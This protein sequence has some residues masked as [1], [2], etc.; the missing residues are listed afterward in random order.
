MEPG[1]GV[2]TFSLQPEQ[3][4]S[5]HPRFPRLRLLS[6]RRPRELSSPGWIPSSERI[7]G[8]CSDLDGGRARFPQHFI[9]S[10]FIF[11]FSPDTS[12]FSGVSSY[13][14]RVSL[15][16]FPCLGLL[17]VIHVTRSDLTQF[18]SPSEQLWIDAV[19]AF[20]LRRPT[21]RVCSQIFPEQ[22]SLTSY[23]PRCPCYREALPSR[24]TFPFHRS[25]SRD[26]LHASLVW[27][28]RKSVFF[29]LGACILAL[30]YSPLCANALSSPFPV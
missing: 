16:P 24:L 2:C 18:F 6:P 9:G 8:L 28:F 4:P 23:I 30:N 17:L 27:E 11:P 15:F 19:S 25:S 29:F 26:N 20:L 7:T 14:T 13:Q 3:F 10:Q 1:V 21:H 5:P 12:N 22:T